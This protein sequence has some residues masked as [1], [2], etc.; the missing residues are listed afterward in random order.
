MIVDGN[1]IAADIY[2]EIT[3]ELSHLTTTRHLTIFTCAPNFATRKYLDMKR[4][5]ATEVGIAV[6]VIEIPD[7]C[8]T[9][10]FVQSVTR[11]SMLTDGVVVQLPLPKHF[12]TQ[13]ILEAIPRTLDVD[14][15]QYD[16]T[17]HLILPPV[18]GAIDEIARRH[19]VMFAGAN[20]VIAGEGRLVGKPAK[21]W[22]D[23]HGWKSTV[24]TEVTP[25]PDTLFSAA[26]ILILGTGQAGL[27]HEENIKTGVVIFD[28]GTSEQEGRLVGD[29]DSACYPKTSLITPVPGGIGPITIAV[30]LRNLVFLSKKNHGM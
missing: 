21:L 10:E 7:T 11:S 23:S 6:N 29:T 30:L 13:T 17:D 24:V 4:R 5:R 26:D 25:H 12:D 27:I 22:A 1:T 16:G 15:S 19:G 2:R 8:T 3:N 28:A 9:E 14:V 20:I 18:I